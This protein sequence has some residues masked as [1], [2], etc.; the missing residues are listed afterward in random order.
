MKVFH[1]VVPLRTGYCVLFGTTGCTR[2][3]QWGR[4]NIWSR[5]TD[6]LS[7]DIR[8]APWQALQDAA[9]LVREEYQQR[10]KRRFGTKH[11]TVRFDLCYLTMRIANRL[12]ADPA[13]VAECKADLQRRELHGARARATA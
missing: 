9:E 4:F 2:P 1:S 11:S 8:G 6:D 10:G 12:L 13:S 5:A 3:D 7:A